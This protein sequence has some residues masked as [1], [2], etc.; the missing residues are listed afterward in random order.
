MKNIVMLFSFAILAVFA[1]SCG[2]GKDWPQPN[3]EKVPVYVISGITGTGAPT[4]VDVYQTT[5][6]L[7]V[8]ENANTL[9]S[10]TTRNYADT[11]DEANYRVSVTA[12]KSVKQDDGT[13]AEVTMDYVLVA[14]KISGA[15]TLDV[16][17]TDAASNV[18]VSNF[19][20]SAV[21]ETEKYN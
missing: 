20:V 14:D 11:S 5:N 3:I 17:T 2:D 13:W 12:V 21:T 18:T 8:F 4:E 6:V 16:T 1:S 10:Y 7:I 15:G 9:K 19:T